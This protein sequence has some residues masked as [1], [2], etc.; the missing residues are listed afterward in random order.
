M[1]QDRDAKIAFLTK[2]MDVLGRI[3]TVPFS[4]PPPLPPSPP[5]PLPPPPPLSLV[6]VAMR[7]AVFVTGSTVRV[8]A[9]K[10]VAGQEAEKTNEFLQVLAIAIMKKVSLTLAHALTTDSSVNLVSYTITVGL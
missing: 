7:V 10:I 4:P 6:F 9:S 8:K 3:L 1:L 5:L 2:A